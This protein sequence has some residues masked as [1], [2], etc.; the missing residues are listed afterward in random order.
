[1]EWWLRARMGAVL[2]IRHGYL[3]LRQQIHGY[4]QPPCRRVFTLRRKQ[5]MGLFPFRICRLGVVGRNLYAR[6]GLAGLPQA[7]AE[8]RHAGEPAATELRISYAV[9]PGRASHTVW[10]PR[11]PVGMD[12]ATRR[13]PRC[14][15][16]AHPAIVDV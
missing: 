10:Q 6:R 9:F 12:H 11:W 1:M 4:G 13:R 2:A 15:Y 3:C 8:H 7:A 5:E 14:G 16:V